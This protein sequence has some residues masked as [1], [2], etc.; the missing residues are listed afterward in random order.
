MNDLGSIVKGHSFIAY[1]LLFQLTFPNNTGPMLVQ[2]NRP[3]VSG[4]NIKGFFI[5]NGGHLGC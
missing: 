3:S 1:C 2:G 5:I 4:K